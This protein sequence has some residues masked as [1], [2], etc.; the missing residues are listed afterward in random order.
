MAAIST[1]RGPIEIPFL[2]T[3]T[4]RELAVNLPCQL[5][6]CAAIAAAAPDPL[7]DDPDSR[8]LQKVFFGSY[9][10]AGLLP[11]ILGIV[12]DLYVLNLP[13]R[14]NPLRKLSANLPTFGV[15][16]AAVTLHAVPFLSPARL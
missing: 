2:F 12:F 7:D 5:F 13:F 9:I 14:V 11:R 16:C 10:M 3:S 4:W 8:R 15:L 6:G 1:F